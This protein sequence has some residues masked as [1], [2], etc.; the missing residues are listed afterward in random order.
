MKKVLL[1]LVLVMVSTAVMAESGEHHEPSIKD[2]IAP[3][4]NFA[5]FFGIIFVALKQKTIDY[6]NK[7]SDEVKSLMSSAAEKNKDAETKLATFEQKIK[8]LETE[9]VQIKNEYESDVVKFSKNSKT[10]TETTIS[11]MQR[12]SEHKLESERNV[13]IE[14][15]N[16]ELV[17]SVVAKT[18]NVITTNAE[19]KKLA[20]SKLVS[21]V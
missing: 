13:L 16:T 17:N 8:N 1:T 7:L 4:V 3:A 10:E 19:A 9:S 6:F 12:D 18:K 21:Q 14:E 5:I 2:L 20:T 15:L 11:R